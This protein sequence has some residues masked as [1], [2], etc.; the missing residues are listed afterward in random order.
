MVEFWL[1]S[2]S[3]GS[4][5]QDLP[6]SIEVS[7]RPVVAGKR[8]NTTDKDT[9]RAGFHSWQHHK[10]LKSRTTHSLDLAHV[11]PLTYSIY[12][13]NYLWYYFVYSLVDDHILYEVF[14][15]SS[16]VF[17]LVISELTLSGFSSVKR[18]QF[19]SSQGG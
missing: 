17:L 3:L 4:L 7:L 19:L 12:F 6:S 14:S 2:R 5:Y 8:L 18:V 9:D 15:Q 10:E 13:S 11:F 16:S 1:I